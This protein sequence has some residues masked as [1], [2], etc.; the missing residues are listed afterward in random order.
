MLR[1]AED[2]NC[3]LAV[4]FSTRMR[5]ETF[6]DRCLHNQKYKMG[7]TGMSV[8][9]DEDKNPC[10]K[11]RIGKKVHEIKQKEIKREELRAAGRKKKNWEARAAASA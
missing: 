4:C 7:F 5:R 3:V 10:S 8:K 9:F 1:I 6:K 2:I 11:C